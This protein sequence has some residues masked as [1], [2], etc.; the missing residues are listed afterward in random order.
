MR[1]SC[2]PS[3]C[4]IFIKIYIIYCMFAFPIR[5]AYCD[6]RHVWPYA[7]YVH[8]PFR[9]SAQWANLMLGPIAVLTVSQNIF[10]FESGR[11]AS[12]RPR[13]RDANLSFRCTKALSHEKK[14]D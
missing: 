13:L 12:A 7:Y 11:F 14:C 6:I 8:F 10:D 9:V 4:V 2:E 3:C 5:L 1:L